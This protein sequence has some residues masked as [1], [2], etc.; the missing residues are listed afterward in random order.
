MVTRIQQPYLDFPCRTWTWPEQIARIEQ[1]EGTSLLPLRDFIKEVAAS[2]YAAAL[3]P[4]SSMDAFL[5]GRTANFSHHEP[6]LRVWYNSV[7]RQFKFTYIQN[8]SLKRLWET[9]APKGRAFA[10]FEYLMQRRLRWFRSAIGSNNSFE[11][12]ALKTTRASS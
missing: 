5:I 6:H 3:F 1:F 10:H 11:S 12:D 8:Q 4:A 7:T 2:P 9:S